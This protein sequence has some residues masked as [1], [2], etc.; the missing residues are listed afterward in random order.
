M[1][2]KVSYQ[3]D[4]RTHVQAEDDTEA[5]T[6]VGADTARQRAAECKEP[7]CCFSSAVGFV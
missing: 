6:V 4:R 1:T 7:V 5:Q 3:T 2:R